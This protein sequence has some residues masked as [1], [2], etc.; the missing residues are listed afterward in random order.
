M[1]TLVVLAMS[2]CTGGSADPVDDLEALPSTTAEPGPGEPGFHNDFPVRDIDYDIYVPGRYTTGTAL[3]A[4]LVLHGMPSN[5]HRA[6]G[7]SGM[8]MLAEEEGFLAVYPSNPAE[9]WSADPDDDA[10]LDMLRTIIEDLT[11][12]WNAD[13]DRIL[14][15]GISNGADMAMVTGV[16]LSD[17]VAGVGAVVPASTGEVARAVDRIDTPMPLVALVGGLDPRHDSGLDL[18]A[19]WQEGMGCEEGGTET[20]AEADVTHYDCPDNTPMTVH[21]VRNGAHEWFGSADDPDGLWAS[22]VL[23]EFLTA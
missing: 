21:D 18:L 22:R 19:A 2:G 9:H 10:D 17:L 11:T 23:W 20:G 5:A 1:A 3:P 8:D 6:R 7:D 14:V 13:P 16:A 15:T 4:V 12:T